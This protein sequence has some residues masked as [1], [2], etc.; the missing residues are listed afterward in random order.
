M[1]SGKKIGNTDVLSNDAKNENKDT[2]VKKIF[3]YDLGESIQWAELKKKC[4]IIDTI[5]EIGFPI[6][7][8]K[9]AEKIKK[10]T[11]YLEFRAEIFKILE[12]DKLKHD[13]HL[14]KD[15]IQNKNN[16]LEKEGKKQ[17]FKN[18]KKIEIINIP[19]EKLLYY[20]CDKIKLN[21][22]IEKNKFILNFGFEE[23]HLKR[24][25][26]ILSLIESPKIANQI[27][28]SEMENLKTKY[29]E[30]VHEMREKFGSKSGDELAS[31]IINN[32]LR[33]TIYLNIK[34][35]IDIG[36]LTKV[37]DPLFFKEIVEDLDK[38]I[39]LINYESK[40]DNLIKTKNS[41]DD[42]FVFFLE[43][44]LK[45][46]IIKKQE[47]MVTLVTKFST[48]ETKNKEVDKE[49]SAIYRFAESQRLLIKIFEKSIKN[50]HKDEYA[51]VQSELCDEHKQYY[52]AYNKLENTIKK[53][54]I[55]QLK[56]GVE[57]NKLKD[58]KIIEILSDGKIQKDDKIHERIEKIKEFYD[59]M[60]NEIK[61][62]A[63]N[64]N[65][66]EHLK[67]A[68]I[69]IY[70]G[71]TI[72]KYRKGPILIL[73]E[74]LESKNKNLNN[75][76]IKK[77]TTNFEKITGRE[78][79]N[80]IGEKMMLLYESIRKQH[81]V[82]IGENTYNQIQIVS[83]KTIEGLEKISKVI[84]PEVQLYMLIEFHN[85]ILDFI[86]SKYLDVFPDK[87][88]QV[89]A[90]IYMDLKHF[91]TIKKRNEVLNYIENKYPELFLY[92]KDH[93][94]ILDAILDKYFDL[95]FY[96]RDNNEI[97]NYIRDKYPEL[98]KLISNAKNSEEVLEFIKNKYFELL[99]LF[100][101]IKKYIL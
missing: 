36:I 17:F 51:T 83:Q 47:E 24:E 90:L 48:R 39:T 75:L 101:Y 9:K 5:E 38:R 23:E 16:L 89:E 58:E 4:R 74:I 73:E 88:N 61:G 86:E 28:K 1:E 63:Y 46:N 66:I 15:C 70:L 69:A 56:D 44:K 43:D 97:L 26:L 100:P 50:S 81:L 11:K 27:L 42:L 20:Y 7:K 57:K 54:L 8:I 37:N 78:E 33:E 3:D 22:N 87:K 25:K 41:F 80:S 93:N 53:E 84:F 21:K 60:K 55:E 6:K 71:K 34:N 59:L 12:E 68:Y 64:K 45:L 49:E 62:F 35:Y 18:L 10:G 72:S 65:S 76:G 99:E 2:K 85:E 77:T 98:L 95:S 52:L 92:A 40:F 94:E 96:I 82:E 14:L 31:Y 13:K 79:E 29:K 30:K 19:C 67:I 32:N 91:P